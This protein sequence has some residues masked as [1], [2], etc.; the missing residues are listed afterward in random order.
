MVLPAASQFIGVWHL[1]A[2]LQAVGRVPP[3]PH[4]NSQSRL[5]ERRPVHAHALQQDLPVQ[6]VG[7]LPGKA[8]TVYLCKLW[9]SQWTAV[10]GQHLLKSQIVIVL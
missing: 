8:K 2:A 9:I 1:A 6:A 7:L 3:H 4:A 5:M 10:Y